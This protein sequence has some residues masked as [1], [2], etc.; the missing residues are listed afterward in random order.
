[1]RQEVFS[2]KLHELDD[3]IGQLHERISRYES[4]GP[5]Q[6]KEEARILRKECKKNRELLY[7]KMKFSRSVMAVKMSEMYAEVEGIL[8]EIREEIPKPKEENR[9]LLA[10]YALD[11]A[12]EAANN[13]LLLSLEAMDAE[14]PKEEPNVE[15]AKLEKKQE[16]ERI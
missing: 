10:E 7:E 6:I 2:A 5:E 13:A 14:G 4:E 8:C 15:A 3:E 1:M 9:I 11:F 12:L 16:E